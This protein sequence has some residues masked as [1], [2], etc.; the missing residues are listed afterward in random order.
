MAQAISSAST[1]DR[2]LKVE[3]HNSIRLPDGWYEVTFRPGDYS[4]HWRAEKILCP[5][6]VKIVVDTTKHDS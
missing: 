5:N 2:C 3:S 6:C 4:G 1:C